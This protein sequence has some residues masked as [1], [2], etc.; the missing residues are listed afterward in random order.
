MFQK[1]GSRDEAASPLVTAPPSNLTPLHYNGS[2]YTIPPAT[3]ATHSLDKI[4][5]SLQL[6]L[7]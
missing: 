7:K 2:P 5:I 3:Q 1:K 4:C 6:Q